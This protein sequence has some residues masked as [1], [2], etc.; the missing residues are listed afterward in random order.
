MN[1]KVVQIVCAY[2][3]LSMDFCKLKQFKQK[4]QSINVMLNLDATLEGTSDF[5][6]IFLKFSV[7]RRRVLAVD[8]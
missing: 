5:L 6:D 1:K 7:F 8:F 4:F 2:C 3:I